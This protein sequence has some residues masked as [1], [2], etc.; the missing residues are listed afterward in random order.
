MHPTMGREYDKDYRILQEET[1][2]IIL[3]TDK[4]AK[5]IREGF[6]KGKPDFQDYEESRKED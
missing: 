6:V 3:Q 5:A 2:V 1:S 4:V